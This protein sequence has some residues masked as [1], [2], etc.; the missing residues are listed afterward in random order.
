[1]VR[2]E[3]K[4]KSILTLKTKISPLRL[5][6]QQKKINLHYPKF[7]YIIDQVKNILITSKIQIFYFKFSKQSMFFNAKRLGR[8]RKWSE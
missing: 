3:M 2:D 5:I 8:N 6:K 1:M 7:I 4:Y